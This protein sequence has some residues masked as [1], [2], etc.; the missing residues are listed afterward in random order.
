MQPFPSIHTVCF[1]A[2]LSLALA[3]SATGQPPT[4]PTVPSPVPQQPLNQFLPLTSFLDANSS[5]SQ[6]LTSD[7]ITSETLPSLLWIIA[8]GGGT[9]TAVLIDSQRG[10]AVTN[11]HVTNGSARVYAVFPAI[12]PS[13]TAVRERKWYVS[14]FRVLET[15]GLFT[16]AHV[17]AEDSDSDLAILLLDTVPRAA[18]EIKYLAPALRCDELLQRTTVHF[19]GNP[20]TTYQGES[21]EQVAQGLWQYGSGVL[22]RCQ[23]DDI[24]ISGSAYR[25]NSGGPLLD[26][27]AFLIGI[28][29]TSNMGST[30]GAASVTAVY[31]LLRQAETNGI[32]SIANNTEMPIRYLYRRRS[33]E[34]WLPSVVDAGKC[35]IHTTYSRETNSQ[36]LF[37]F[38]TNNSQFDPM[39]K[40]LHPTGLVASFILD[41]T[42]CSLPHM[43]SHSAP[44]LHI[45]ES[46]AGQPVT[47]R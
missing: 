39:E 21:G 43:F 40:P 13:G 17:I 1:A 29:K 3:P 33:S 14:N 18:R 24:I 12:Q 4:E 7:Q 37:D 23:D 11:Q 28:L 32:V 15:L 8:P 16:R 31:R 34:Q 41:R 2:L 30:A 5:P 38:I 27:D 35:N 26:H 19:L 25:G 46:I 47:G 42:A 10:L 6:Q 9:A 44:T 36:V 22:D 20:I 45:I